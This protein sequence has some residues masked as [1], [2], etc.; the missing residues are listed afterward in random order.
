MPTVCHWP[1]PLW[2]AL[3]LVGTLSGMSSFGAAPMSG[4]KPLDMKTILS[5][6]LPTEIALSPDT[7]YV[8]VVVRTTDWDKS[9]YRYELRLWSVSDGT[10]RLLLPPGKDI[11][12]LQWRPDGRVLAF[13]TD[14]AGWAEPEDEA[15]DEKE[16]FPQVWVW[17][18]DG[19][20][21]QPVTDLPRGARVFRWTPDGRALIVLTEYPKPAAE[22]EY[23]RYRKK[24]KLDEEVVDREK[25][26]RA[27][28]RVT[29]EE[30]SPRPTP[31]WL[32][33]GDFG[34][35]DFDVHPRAPWLVF[36]TNYT[37]K[38]DDAMKF[39]LWVLD[40]PAGTARP[41][42][43]A[44]GFELRP[45]FSP[46]GT[47]LAF[48]ALWDPKYSYARTDV[49]VLTADWA[50]L[51]RPVPREQWQ[52]VSA[53]TDAEARDFRWLP[54]DRLAVQA[55]KGV[56][57]W[58][59]EVRPGVS[60]YGILLGDQRVVQAFDVVPT[61]PDPWV[62]VWENAETLPDVW[63]LSAK[64]EPR[65][66]TDLNP[67]FRNYAL[68]P[69][70]VIRWTSRDGKAIEGIFV[71]PLTPPP[72]GQKPPLLV[73]V[74]GGPNARVAN[75]LR[76]YLYF[77]FFAAHGYAVLAPNFRG[78]SGYGHA[79]ALANF[80]DLGG[81]D[82][83]DIMAGVDYVVAQGWAD[84][85]RMGIFGGSY[86][87]YMTNWAI[88]QTNRFKAAVSM[89]GIF[90]LITD[91]SNSY[92]PSWEP[93]YLGDYYWN[94]LETYLKHSPALYVKN[95]QTPVLIIHGK[96]DPKTFISNS[97]EM[98]QALQFLKKTVEFVVYPREEHGLREP[99]HKLDEMRRVLA[100]F[101]RY[102]LGQSRYWLED[103]VE[104]EG[105]KLR[106]V[107]WKPLADE[108]AA[109]RP[110]S[111]EGSTYE[112]ELILTPTPQ[113][114]ADLTLVVW[115]EGLSDFQVE[116]SDGTVLLPTAILEKLWGTT[117]Y[118]EGRDL[119]WHLSR[120]DGRGLPRAYAIRLAFRV[121]KEGTAPPMFRLRGFPP[122]FLATP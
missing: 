93:D 36:A 92:L 22:K 26:P 109:P 76:Q 6:N 39:D 101:D 46:D 2:G 17:R 111:P 28:V 4:K 60:S 40:I 57:E 105:W 13:I 43:D 25:Y 8:A 85:E 14:R 89:F 12:H 16:T 83:Q 90:N 52:F 54:D 67:E 56:W 86:G 11:R 106:V 120:G 113:A 29:L 95:V 70:R 9:R 91:F 10:S 55:E 72:P 31:E 108:T 5:W 75:T 79:F 77:Q 118:L 44:P 116:T 68:A 74:H 48:L 41:L 107:A 61:R 32:Y 119:T 103:E 37:G 122:V 50:R 23:E 102:V 98:Y 30:A 71:E 84:P 97:K 115:K 34:I 38:P 104:A 100:W 73:A 3:L 53:V 66:L 88:T 121:P 82:F 21:P 42:T 78:S 69:Q 114:K 99:Q 65:R 15:K 96:E 51:D 94:D 1:R 62:A 59:F 33:V 18:T 19:G 35:E 87:G 27:F 20:L 110:S 49:V 58:I 117:A 24:R 112:L 63:V 81:G 64:G 47:K 80:K 7:K 45:R